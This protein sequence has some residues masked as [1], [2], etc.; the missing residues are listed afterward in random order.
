[1]DLA[2][3][4]CLFGR[5]WD[6][7]GQRRCFGRPLVNSSIF[8]KEKSGEHPARNG[9]EFGDEG[10]VAMFGGCQDGKFQRVIAA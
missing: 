10:W 9:V 6:L 2:G 3:S 4:E 8:A 5:A 1:M 7:D